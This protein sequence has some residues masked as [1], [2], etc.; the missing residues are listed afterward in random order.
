MMTADELIDWGIKRSAHQFHF[1]IHYMLTISNCLPSYTL[2]RS[3]RFRI[4]RNLGF[5]HCTRTKWYH[6]SGTQERGKK[7]RVLARRIFKE[8]KA[9][10]NAN[11]KHST[12]E[13]TMTRK[14]GTK[15][16]DPRTCKAI[17][18]M[19][20]LGVRNCDIKSTIMC[21]NALFRK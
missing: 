13:R 14:K 11:S 1:P 15:I 9:L 6:S 17:H 8:N 20:C 4:W 10:G 3:T 16:I 5:V 19:S 21:I 12:T 7:I 2:H 18:D